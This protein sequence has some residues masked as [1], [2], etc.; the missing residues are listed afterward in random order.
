MPDIDG[1][2]A[3]SGDMGHKVREGLA[4]FAGAAPFRPR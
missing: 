3:V 4:S 2:F 1:S